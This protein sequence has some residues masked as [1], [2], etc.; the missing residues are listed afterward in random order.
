MVKDLIVILEKIPA[1]I[2]AVILDFS[3]KVPSFLDFHKI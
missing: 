3:V 1:V 2:L